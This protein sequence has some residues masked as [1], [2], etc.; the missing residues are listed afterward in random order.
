MQMLLRCKGQLQQLA[1][2]LRENTTH[3]GEIRQQ[4]KQDRR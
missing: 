4:L 3:Q 2:R 1:Q